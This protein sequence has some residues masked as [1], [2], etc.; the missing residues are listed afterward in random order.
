[1]WKRV[2]IDKTKF[3]FLFP[4][5]SAQAAFDRGQT[6]VEFTLVFVL[7]MAVAWIP[8]E[9]GLGFYTGQLALNASREGAR[10]AAADPGLDSYLGGDLT[11][12]CNRPCTSQADGTI[13]RETSDRIGSAMLQNATVTAT[14]DAATG[15][16]C[17]RKVTV[18]VAGTY[19]FF[20][21]Q[22]LHLLKVSSVPDN[23][24]VTRTSRMRWEH[25]LNCT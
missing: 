20:F 12:S 4:S 11:E 1:M 17:N 2:F 9:F 16:N 24:T 25:Q 23:V 19:N 6:L 7:F 8:A 15:G 13:L 10:I 18:T 22:L 14:L 3:R 5:Q 21:Y